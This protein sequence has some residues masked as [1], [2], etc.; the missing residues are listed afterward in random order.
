MHTYLSRQDNVL[1]DKKVNG[2]HLYYNIF[3]MFVKDN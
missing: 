3:R 1:R 2:K